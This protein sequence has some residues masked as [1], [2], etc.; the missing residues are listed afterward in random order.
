MPSRQDDV[1]KWKHF[2]HYWPFMRRIHRSP[3]DC[4]HKVSMMRS[5]DVSFDVSLRKQL[6][7]HSTGRWIEM[8]GW[9]FDVAVMISRTIF[10][11]NNS[12]QI[13]LA[14]PLTYWGQDKMAAIFQT[15][16]S[17]EFSWVKMLKFR[18]RFH[19][20]LFPMVQLTIFQRWF[21]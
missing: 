4:L 1:I 12:Q 8:F 5:F 20:S 14:K 16:F 21:R 19:R 2:L 15:I 10:S 3:V 11:P 17:N 7:N 6:K 9:S 18:L 13:W